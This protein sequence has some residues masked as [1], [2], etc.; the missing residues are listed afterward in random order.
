MLRL[1]IILSI[2]CCYSVIF[3]IWR[4]T[5]SHVRSTS[6]ESASFF[7][8]Y[9]C[10]D[11]R[12]LSNFCIFDKDSLT[13]YRNSSSVSLSGFFCSTFALSSAKS[14]S[15][16]LILSTVT[17]FLRISFLSSYM[18]RNI[19]VSPAPSTYM[20]PRSTSFPSSSVFMRRRSTFT[21]CLRSS[22][23]SRMV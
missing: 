23:S 3:A 17:H 9:I 10:N 15:T 8:I 1:L 19:S 14:F 5:C 13:D 2:F 16:L 22:I 4:S 21:S 11:Y 18:V 6:N 7:I 20:C 12:L